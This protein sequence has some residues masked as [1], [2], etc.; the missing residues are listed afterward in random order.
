MK[1][2]FDD[3]NRLR[4]LLCEIG[5]AASSRDFCCWILVWSEGEVFVVV[6]GE[7]TISYYKKPNNSRPK[8]RYLSS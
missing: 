2:L 8:S 3:S 1:D 5:S 6:V 7:T 4:P